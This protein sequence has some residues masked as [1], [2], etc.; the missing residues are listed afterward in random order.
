MYG[1]VSSIYMYSFKASTVG[2]F[3]ALLDG[4]KVERRVIAEPK[5][6]A[7]IV[8]SNVSTGA[9]PNSLPIVVTKYGLSRKL[10]PTPVRPPKIPI[11][12]DSD[13]NRRKSCPEEKPLAES[14][15]ISRRL[16]LKDTSATVVPT[17]QATK[18]TGRAVTRK[19]TRIIMERS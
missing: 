13:K 10:K 16:R 17:Y 18:N 3:A 8:T 6:I 9:S 5:M 15:P 11:S 14:K 1:F 19:E 12:N 4:L 2:N 7:R